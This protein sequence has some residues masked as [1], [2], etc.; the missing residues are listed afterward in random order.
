MGKKINGVNDITNI[1]KNAGNIG[2]KGNSV[3]TVA[4]KG[5]KNVTN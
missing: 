4:Q 5:A 3:T 1:P 2:P